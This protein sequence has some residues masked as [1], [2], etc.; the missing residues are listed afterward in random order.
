[1]AGSAACDRGCEHEKQLESAVAV[2]QD[3]PTGLARCIAGV[4]E[5]TEGEPACAGCPC[6]WR[7]LTACPSGCAVENEELVREPRDAP[8]LCRGGKPVSA[9]PPVDAGTTTCPNEGERFVCRSSTVFACPK[10]SSAVPVAVCTNGC[11]REDEALSDPSVDV[12][13]ATTV[14]CRRDHPTHDAGVMAP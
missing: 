14:M 11:A 5:V 6:G 2:K 7:R 9:P 4:V 13:G 8:S 12:G 1:V 3:C 10:G